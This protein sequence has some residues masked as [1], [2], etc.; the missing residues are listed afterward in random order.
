MR[1]Y[2]FFFC[3]QEGDQLTS[4]KNDL[5]KTTMREKTPNNHTD[6][7]IMQS[8]WRDNVKFLNDK[9]LFEHG[10]FSFLWQMCD[11]VPRS[12]IECSLAA[13]STD[14][15]RMLELNA[16]NNEIIFQAAKLAIT[17]LFDTYVHSR[18]KSNMLQWIDLLIK[19]F[20]S[21]RDA[22][23]WFLEHMSST[24]RL[25]S[26]PSDKLH[27]C[28]KIFFKCPNSSIRQ[29]FQRLLLHAIA[30]LLADRSEHSK[31]I[32]HKF[33]AVYLNLLA[34]SDSTAKLYNIRFMSEYF[35]FLIELVNNNAKN[36]HED[37]DP[38]DHIWLF[39]IKCG[40]V[41]KCSRFYLTNRRPTAASSKT[42]KPPVTQRRLKTSK[43]VELNLSAS[44]LDSNLNNKSN[45]NAD[46]KNVIVS[47]PDVPISSDLDEEKVKIE[48]KQID[49][50]P[51]EDED[52]ADEEEEDE[53]DE[54]DEEDDEEEEDQDVIPLHDQK[55]KLK[56]FDKIIQLISI[57]CEKY[58]SYLHAKH[59]DQNWVNFKLFNF[60]Y[61][62][63][64]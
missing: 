18:E 43:K 47:S 27:W 48:S 50:E 59:H 20:N 31:K 4:N 14:T 2:L 40:A 17:F 64:P 33:L 22:C 25:P 49:D 1:F 41:N 29:M 56:V 53:L 19:L 36:E 8:I 61:N 10:Y 3:K 12:L 42:N 6:D 23:K 39:L 37:H 54:E 21:S 62:R 44:S 5:E 51:D 9:I 52:E 28:A 58:S 57:L 30:R 63:I 13:E 34:H 46:V 32:I 24:G 16:H 11:S 35:A 45:N 7:E 60:S 15:N 26:Q 38:D 55:S